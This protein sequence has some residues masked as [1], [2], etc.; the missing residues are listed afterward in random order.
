MCLLELF[1]TD[2]FSH[3]LTYL[4][5]SAYYPLS[6]VCKKASKALSFSKKT[7]FTYVTTSVPLVQWAFENGC[8]WDERICI[9]A[10]LNDALDVLIW[11]YDNSCDWSYKTTC[12]AAQYGRLDILKWA[13]GNGIE[14]SKIDYYAARGGQVAVIDWLLKETTI[15]SS[16]VSIINVAARAGHRDVLDWARNNGFQWDYQT[17][18]SVARGGH[19]ELLKWLHAEGCPWNSETTLE[20]SFRGHFELLKWAY[21]NGCEVD[22]LVCENNPE[23]VEWALSHNLP[24]LWN[25]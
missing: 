20:A 18:S 13:Y 17:A 11:A 24:V 2:E 12:Y 7:T 15:Q 19:L 16:N 1:D 5:K 3:M 6:R 25:H 22:E 8:P 9:A 14:I 23:I 21:D 4:D 10:V